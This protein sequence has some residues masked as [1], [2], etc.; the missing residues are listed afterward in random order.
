MASKTVVVL[1]CAHVKPKVS[2]ERAEWLGKFLYDLRPDYVVDLGDTADMLSL[3]SHDT[4]YPQ[5]MVASAYES[6]IESYHDFQD[7]LRYQFQ[8]NK[9]KM[10]PFYGFEGNHEHRIKRAIT[11]DP[12]LEGEKYGISFKHLDHERYYKEYH[13]YINSAPSIWNYDGV[14]YAHYIGSGNYGTAMS[15]DHHA[16]NLLKKRMN[17]CTVGH[18]HKRNIY[19]RE[20]AKAVGLVAGCFK[21]GKED[22]AGQANGEWW[23]GVVVKRQLEDG[24][25]NPEFV[26][27][28]QLKEEY[29]GGGKN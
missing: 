14:D 2:N 1:T 11:N 29:G 17:S 4:R 9:K 26:S 15:G 13:P 23:S 22:W 25:Y 7:K 6:D 27:L 18:S 5:K 19:F 3:S 8:K 28:K 24:Y 16:Y 12:R 21:G 20:D 10:P